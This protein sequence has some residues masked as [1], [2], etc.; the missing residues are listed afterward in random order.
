VPSR[1]AGHY[2]TT[3]NAISASARAFVLGDGPE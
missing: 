1:I 2:A 3:I